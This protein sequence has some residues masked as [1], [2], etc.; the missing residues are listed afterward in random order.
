MRLLDCV[1]LPFV[2]MITSGG[3][4]KVGLGCSTTTPAMDVTLRPVIPAVIMLALS[5][6]MKPVLPDAL[7][8]V[9]RV[10]IRVCITGVV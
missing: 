4:T 7:R 6:P 1:A 2:G 5:L 8:K 9:E 10:E 3:M